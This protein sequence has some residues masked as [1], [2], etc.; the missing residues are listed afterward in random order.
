MCWHH[1][2]FRKRAPSPNVFCCRSVPGWSPQISCSLDLPPLYFFSSM[3]SQP[4]YRSVLI[5]NSI[6]IVTLFL[7]LVGLF[8]YETSKHRLEAPST[9]DQPVYPQIHRK[10]KIRVCALSFWKD[11]FVKSKLCSSPNRDIQKVIALNWTD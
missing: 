8:V 7:M 4:I 9:L 10:V 11:S 3:L 2:N 5:H 6:F 1:K